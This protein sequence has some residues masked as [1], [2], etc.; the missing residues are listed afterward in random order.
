MGFIE[1]LHTADLGIN[2]W[3]ESME[4]LFSESAI[5]MYSLMGINGIES[6]GINK[7][8][9][10]SG[11]DNECLLINFLNELLYYIENENTIFD[12]FDI[13]FGA[14]SCQVKMVPHK[15]IK[16]RNP[17]KAVT[18]HNLEIINSNHLYQ[19]EIVFDI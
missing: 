14:N 6:S 10:V 1:I 16:C 7:S 11:F 5:G 9:V 18:F 13:S 8:I 3:G 4:E 12:G 19:V 2:V 15:I 17:I